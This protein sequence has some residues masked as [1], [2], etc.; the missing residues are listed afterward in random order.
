MALRISDSAAYCK[1]ANSPDKLITTFTNYLNQQFPEHG[2][3]CL[4]HQFAPQSLR[5]ISETDQNCKTFDL[6]KKDINSLAS[7]ALEKRWL[8][9]PVIGLSK[10]PDY[11]IVSQIQILPG[12]EELDREFTRLQDIY[13][14]LVKMI[15][16]TEK[17][18]RDSGASLVSQ[19]THDINSLIVYLQ[20]MHLST[21]LEKKI[22]YLDILT[23]KLLLFIREME[24]SCSSI[25]LNDL[26][27]SIIDL[28]TPERIRLIQ[29]QKDI[30]LSCDVELINM[31]LTA[32]ISNA[33]QAAPGKKNCIDLKVEIL[34]GNSPYYKISWAR[35]SIIDSFSGIT[36]DFLPL[37]FKPFFTTRKSEG[38]P[39][40]GLSLT[41]KIIKAHRG[42]IEINNNSSGG[43]TVD[44][45]LP[46][47]N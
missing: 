16:L 37:V 40:L 22:S 13:S 25:Y 30:K 19:L 24:L 2:F 4:A 43:L 21:S 27:R 8:I 12:D 31:A 11:L 1:D 26:I 23:P 7:G 6:F 44:C 5:L 18:A 14:G 33:Y 15:E 35:I 38:H 36:S 34:S 39:G 32:I 10:Q 47:E 17:N 29:P 41:Q 28:N 46:L 45:Y 42:T 20:D 9:R 3:I